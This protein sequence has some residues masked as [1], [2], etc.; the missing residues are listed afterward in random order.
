MLKSLKISH[1]ALKLFNFSRS[2]S[3]SKLENKSLLSIQGNLA[4]EFLQ[5]LITNDMKSIKRPQSFMYSYVLNIKGRIVTDAFIYH[6]DEHQ[7]MEPRYLIELDNQCAPYVASYLAKHNIRRKVKINT[8][9]SIS[10]WVVM[11]PHNAPLS[12]LSD[13]QSWLPLKLDHSGG[14]D[15]Q[16]NL[17]FYAF[18]PRGIPGWSG[19][20]LLRSGI[21]ASLVF[22]GAKCE[23][24][25]LSSYNH[26]RWRLGLPEGSDELLQ[27]KTLPLE[28]NGDLSG[29]VSFSKGCYVGQELT[30]RT[31][32]TGVVRRRYLPVQLSP[33]DKS[34]VLLMKP[35]D[36]IDLSQSTV[37]SDAFDA[38]SDSGK[39]TRPVGWLRAVDYVTRKSSETLE[40]L[41]LLRLSETAAHQS[42]LRVLLSSC[43]Y[44]VKPSVPNWWPN[45]IAPELPRNVM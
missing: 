13:R 14:P 5:G 4:A 33:V 30:A 45:D 22:T 35:D 34:Q 27:G 3:T 19:R 32:F 44:H 26:V 25:T 8:D 18:D 36:R 2:L 39:S 37:F 29:A 16:Q 10:V 15:A 11:P 20:I 7:S 9:E 41:A 40:G 38:G 12:S 42:E 21:E 6:L 1:F 28:S 31:R 23:Y 24:H 43:W 17:R